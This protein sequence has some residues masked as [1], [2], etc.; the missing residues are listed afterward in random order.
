[1]TIDKVSATIFQLGRLSVKIHIK[2]SKENSYGETVGVVRV[3]NFNDNNY[4]KIEPNGFLTID[5]KSTEGEWD[6]GILVN[7]M[8]LYHIIRG[9]GDFLNKMKSPDLYGISKSGKLILYADKSKECT[10]EITNIS[11]Q[12]RIVLIPT[13]V[14]DDTEHTYEGCRLILNTNACFID[15]SIDAIESLRYM[16]SKIDI[17][18]YSMHLYNAY[19]HSIE[20]AAVSIEELK[21]TPKKKPH[22]L[23]RPLEKEEVV[24]NLPKEPEDK[25]IF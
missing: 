6:K 22:I 7:T 20:K 9:I 4:M 12:Q 18:T 11:G 25:N 2:I 24:S 23:L 10:V 3:F 21:I 17:Y 14:V 19:M 5:I 1:M 15:L 8:N 13:I 16:L